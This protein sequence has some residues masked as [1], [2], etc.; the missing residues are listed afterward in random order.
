MT[1]HFDVLIVGAGLSGI[2]AAV[3]LQRD[4][5]GR[6]FALL[7]R[8]AAIGGTWD[9]FRYPGIRS[10]S[11]MF[12]LG[13]RFKP[14]TAAKSIA[15]GPSIL[16][17]VQETAAE[18]DVTRHVRFDHKVTAASWSSETARWTVTAATGDGTTTLTCNFLYMCSGYY[19]Y[20]EGHRPE[21]AGEADFAGTIV[22]PQFWPADLDYAGKRVVVIGSGA[23]AV[24]LVPEMAKTASHVT[25][26]QRSPTYVISRPGNDALADT[27]RKW[28]PAKLAYSLI[29]FKNVGWGMY[30]YR[31]TRKQP[32]KVRDLLLGGVRQELGPDY[33]VATHFTPRYNPWDQRLCLVPDADLFAA[34]RSGSASVV[35]DTVERFTPGGIRLASGA[36]LPAD[37]VVTATGLK[38]IALGGMSVTVDG[39]AIKPG[40]CIAYKGMMFS[41]V[42]NLALSLGYINASWDAAVGPDRRLC[43]PHPEPHGGDRHGH[44]DAG[45]RPRRRARAP[46]LRPVVGLRPARRR[47]DAEVGQPPAVAGH[48]QLH[49]RHDGTALRQGRRWRAALYD[50]GRG[51]GQ[52]AGADRGLIARVTPWASPS[53]RRGPTAAP[54]SP[55]ASPPP[56]R[57]AA[58]PRDR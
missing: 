33:D 21:F 10:D 56:R 52:C 8:R 48:R 27:L 16:S 15:D 26:L 44:R 46:R 3:H 58:A 13:Y 29:R 51:A 34:I 39:A 9:L 18:H 36:E 2:G 19:S 17:Y 5:P 42:P 50:R 37:V 47:R 53:C 45:A 55:D 1:D 23:T 4:C 6:T 7:E 14:W 49:A 31:M 40:D 20:D 30:F 25:M 54:T 12:T 57:A 43:R 11:D 22:H 38:L 28:L 41:N 24:T 35:T 32:A